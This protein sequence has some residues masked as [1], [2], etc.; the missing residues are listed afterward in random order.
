[1]PQ[2]QSA[3]ANAI[4]PVM[5]AVDQEKRNALIVSPDIIWTLGNVCHVTLPVRYV[6]EPDRPNALDAMMGTILYLQPPA[7]HAQ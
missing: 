4:L 1:M 7:R 3:V 6:L 5:N 2:Q